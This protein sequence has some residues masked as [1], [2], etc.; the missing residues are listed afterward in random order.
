ME[1]LKDVSLEVAR[2]LSRRLGNLQGCCGRMEDTAG[3]GAHCEG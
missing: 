1:T 3:A 2:G